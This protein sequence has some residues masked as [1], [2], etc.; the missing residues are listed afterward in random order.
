MQSQH[1][2]K[3]TCLVFEKIEEVVLK[4]TFKQSVKGL[5][6]FKIKM[7]STNQPRVLTRKALIMT[8]GDSNQLTHKIVY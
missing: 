4:I 5:L 2:K 7:I 3:K 8:F 6:Y 1:Q